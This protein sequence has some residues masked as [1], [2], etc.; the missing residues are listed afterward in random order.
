VTTKAISDALAADAGVTALVADRISPVLKSQGQEL[1][2]ITVTSVSAAPENALGGYDGT[3]GVRIQV[4]S[5]ASTYAEA[6]AVASASRAALQA[7]GFLCVLDGVEDYEPATK[8][9]Q[10]IQDWFFYS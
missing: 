7:A 1:P 2:A 3:D 4:S 8:T 6:L 10:V 5:W 9:H